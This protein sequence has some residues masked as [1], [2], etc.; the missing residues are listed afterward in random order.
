VRGRLYVTVQM[1]LL[2]ALGLSPLWGR[3]GDV[4]LV[5]TLA[6]A[7]ILLAG[8]VACAVALRNLGDALTPL[9]EPRP[10]AQ[11][12]ATGLYRWVR[13]PIY[14][15]VLTS[16]AGWTLL[17]PSW[18]TAGATVALVVLFTLKSRYEE[19]LLREWYVGYA[20]YARCTPRFVPRPRRPLSL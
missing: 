5:V 6:G 14:S 1:L 11:L 8:L 3:E 13:H 16:A 7:V 19:S 4:P 17:F 18:W 10:D 20:D 12:V 9:P 2:V 15:G